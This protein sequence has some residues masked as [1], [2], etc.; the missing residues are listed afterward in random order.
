MFI[1]KYFYQLMI[2]SLIAST[3]MNCGEKNKMINNRK[4][5][6]T[7][8]VLMIEPVNFKYNEQSA[9][10]NSFMKHEADSVAQVEALKQFYDYVAELRKYGIR[11]IIVKDT[12]TPNTPDAIFPNN[13]FS[14]HSEGKVV[15]YPMCMPNRREE[16]KLDVKD[17]IAMACPNYETVDLTQLENQGK[18]LEGTGSMVLDRVNKIA[19]AC[20][21]PRTSQE[22]LDE[23]CKKMG[24]K[25]ITFH[26]VDS[27]GI[28]VYHTNV[29]MCVGTDFAI[30]CEDA[31]RSNNEM[32]MLKSSLEN[33]GKEI[34]KITL[35]QMINYA[36][37]MLELNDGKGKTFIVMSKTARESLTPVQVEQISKFGT[38]IDADIH[39]IEIN[40]GGSA[41]CM[42]AEI[43]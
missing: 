6:S 37:N 16:R 25:P 17:S 9:I 34:I 43:Y 8:T 29:M 11:V 32:K 2:C 3:F 39:T 22:A 23:F 19:Y 18:Y 15:L 14:T 36:G 33:S 7:S 21:S 4:M 12:P 28:P 1:K 31:I 20:L 38:I 30:V 5:N 41:R 35:E 26:A 42:L 24:Y 13:W 10:T 27:A 40:G